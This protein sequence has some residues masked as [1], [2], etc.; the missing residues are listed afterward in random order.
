MATIPTLFVG[1]Y[2]IL[3]MKIFSKLFLFLVLLANCWPAQ[4]Q[5]PLVAD[6]YR[7]FTS[8]GKLATLNDII[9]AANDMDVVYLGENHD[10]AVGHALQLAVFN[11]IVEKYRPT[12]QVA[13]SLEMFERDTQVVLDE[14]LNGLITEKQFLASARPWNNYQQDYKPLVELAKDRNLPVIAANAPRRYVNMV[15]RG[16]RAALEKLSPEAL[17]WLAPL[18]YGAPSTAYAAKFNAL[19][20]ARHNDMTSNMLQSQSLWDA[21]MAYFVADYLQKTQKPLVV[22]LNGKFHSESRLGTVEHLLRYR[23]SARALVVTVQYDEN[24][25]NFDEKKHRGLGDFVVLTN[26]KIK[27]SF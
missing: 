17:N 26:P 11:E 23:P 25:P 14:Y 10:D 12:R 22:H 15:T 7:I 27:R 9:A 4:A 5:I 3:P 8:D 21:T 13:L 16:G 18:P 20:G 19:M 2:Y 1:F 24:F 6:D